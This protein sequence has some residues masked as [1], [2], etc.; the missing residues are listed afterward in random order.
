MDTNG[1]AIYANTNRFDEITEFPDHLAFA[2]QLLGRYQW[3]PETG[4]K[5]KTQIDKLRSKHD[6]KLLN[7]SVIGEFSTGKS[8]F[9]NALLRRDNFLESS[10]L[11]GTT[12]TA[13][14]IENSNT[15]GVVFKYIEE[16]TETLQFDSCDELKR[17]IAEVSADAETAGRIYSVT[18][19]LPA[20][21]LEK[22]GFRI[23]DTPGINSNEHWHDTVTIR[24]IEDLSDL[25]IIIIDA[26]KPLPQQ[27]CEFINENLQSILDQCV[28][29]VTKINM[30]RKRELESVMKYIKDKAEK[31]FSIKDPIILPYSSTD[32]LDN[33]DKLDN[34]IELP[35]LVTASL[36]SEKVM[37]DHMSSQKSIVQTLNLISLADDMYGMVQKHLDDVVKKQELALADVNR[38]KNIGKEIDSF[39]D[40]EIKNFINGEFSKDSESAHAK[41][42]EF[43]V[44]GIHVAYKVSLNRMSSIPFPVDLAAYVDNAMQQDIFRAFR[45]LVYKT[46]NTSKMV[47]DISMKFFNEVQRRLKERFAEFRMFDDD[48]IGFPVSRLRVLDYMCFPMMPSISDLIPKGKMPSSLIP[49]SPN[50]LQEGRIAVQALIENYTRR[51]FYLCMEDV[52]NYIKQTRDQLD[53]CIHRYAASCAQKIQERAQKNSEAITEEMKK[54]NED[55]GHINERK[56]KLDMVG[57]V[58]NLMNK[59]EPVVS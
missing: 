31:E 4:L 30:I 3:D 48:P 8:T 45:A 55:A 58:M 56:A 52:G 9:V 28:F 13:S 5:F 18:I 7:L 6:D 50:A 32:I 35:E 46:N 1:Q 16:K 24:T 59:K 41:I 23:I 49:K 36:N 22:K 20:P 19:R 47:D 33:I 21:L 29:I 14:V 11:Q 42:K 38:Q 53:D 34:S 17:H 25:S 54:L 40:H 57:R 37:T 51:V 39:L 10:S 12:T 43:I 44:N 26:T 2:Q 27:F 15:Y